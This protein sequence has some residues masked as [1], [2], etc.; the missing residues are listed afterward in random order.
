MKRLVQ[1]SFLILIASKSMASERYSQFEVEGGITDTQNF[2]IHG[3]N[4]AD[5]TKGW[6]KSVPD[7][8]L[9]Y[10][11][12]KEGDWNYGLVVQPLSVNYS[13]VLKSNLTYKTTTYQLG[14]PAKVDF[15]FPNL[16][17]TA[18]YVV[19]GKESTGDYIRAG[20]SAIVRYVDV[21]LSTS[22]NSFSDKNF[23]VLP[24]VNIE[25]SKQINSKY[26][27]FTR[28]DFI[29]SINGNVF[30]DGL[31]DVYFGV[32]NKLDNGDSVDAGVRLFFGGYDPKKAGDLATRIFYNS[33]VVRYNW[34]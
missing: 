30:L 7:V 10:W 3:F 5:A 1:L 16:R 13:D 4:Q 9:E 31:Y 8:R 20:G 34:R 23:L 6:K 14:T 24:I 32:K 17:F 15:Q 11:S 28:S 33:F 26:S 19:S 22:A 18:N 2:A 12:K 21:R 29:P 27:L 25:A